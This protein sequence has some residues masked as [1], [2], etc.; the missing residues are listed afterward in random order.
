MV[1]IHWQ[2]GVV[3]NQTVSGGGGG[4]TPA[5]TIATGASGN[6]DNCVKFAVWNVNQMDYTGTSTGVFD[7]STSTLGTA[8]SPTRTTQQ[9]DIPATDLRDNAYFNGS[10]SLQAIEALF[11]VGC[12]IR[13]NGSSISNPQVR[14]LSNGVINASV[15]NSQVL[16]QQS[17]TTHANQQDSTTFTTGF[18]SQSGFHD[19]FLNPFGSS[20]HFVN[21]QLSGKSGNVPQAGDFFIFRIEAAAN[22]DGTVCFATHDLRIDLV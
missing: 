17:A 19:L 7:G 1:G 20:H 16:L 3:Q 15:S 18:N 10:G 22:I 5:I 4:P 11:V 21:L 8:S 6:F 2:F 14:I 9:E 13:H 12:Y